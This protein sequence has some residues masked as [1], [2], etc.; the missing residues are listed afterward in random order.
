MRKSAQQLCTTA[1]FRSLVNLE[2]IPI[3]QAILTDRQY[4][5]PKP[6]LNTDYMVNPAWKAGASMSQARQTPRADTHTDYIT[7]AQKEEGAKIQSLILA[8]TFKDCKKRV[9]RRECLPW[10]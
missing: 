6:G 9:G 3:K 1:L 10:A 4:K 5:E 7:P 2:S 8:I